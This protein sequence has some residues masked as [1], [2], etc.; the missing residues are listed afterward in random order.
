M[1][2]IK[3]KIIL[4]YTITFGLMLVGFAFVIYKST[5]NT[6]IEKLDANLKTYS[7]VVQTELEEQVGEDNHLDLNEIKKIEKPGLSNVKIQLYDKSNTSLIKDPKIALLNHHNK[8]F[9]SKKNSEFATIKI[10]GRQFRSLI[11]PV[12]TEDDTLY[13]LQTAASMHEVSE[14]LERLLYLFIIIIPF[15]LIITGIMAYI[16]SVA[17]FKPITQMVK[18]AK[19]ISA[20]NLDQRLQLPK[21]NDEVKMLGETLN[22][23][24]KRIADAFKSQKQFVADA[25]HEFRTPLTVIQTELEL[26]Q[27]EVEKPVVKESINIALSEVDSLTKLTGSL[28]TLARL[29]SF[30]T[31]L[32]ISAL[33]IDELLIECVQIMKQTAAKKNIKIDL[34]I[35]EAFEVNGDEEKLK[36]VFINLIDNSIK[37][38]ASDKIVHVKLIPGDKNN[39]NVIIKDDGYGIS[40]SE[41]DKIFRRFYRSNEMRS[42]ETG[43]GLGLAI[44]K[45]IISMHGGMIDVKSDLG[46]GTTFKIILPLE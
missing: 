35:S 23:M 14:D 30:Q 37:Y 33:R 40:Q 34:S 10:N 31:S 1:L 21:A 5:E 20:K 7:V 22:E 9:H 39:I 11:M 38:S 4:A 18:T 27:K 12:E 44:V 29:D 25:S 41:L 8:I 36:R 28:I 26:A 24:I 32:N 16:I 15:G 2:S 42:K 6:A 45:E 17:A 43:S 3:F 46:R 13:F 19:N